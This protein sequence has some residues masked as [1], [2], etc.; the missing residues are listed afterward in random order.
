M[1]KEEFDVTNWC[2]GV[3]VK[4]LET[5]R[6]FDVSGVDFEWYTV[7]VRD[8]GKLRHSPCKLVEIVEE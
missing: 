5:Q 1:T 8:G 3:K 7:S 2:K 6:V 4:E